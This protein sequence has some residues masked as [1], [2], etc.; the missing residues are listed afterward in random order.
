LADL[1]PQELWNIARQR[2]TQEYIL[3]Q[4]EGTVKQQR[5]QQWH[6]DISDVDLVYQGNAPVRNLDETIKN[7]GWKVTNLV[8]ANADD[9]SRLTEESNDSV[10]CH[11]LT[12]KDADEK[13]ARIRAAIARSWWMAGDG[14]FIKPEL[15]LDYAM[16]GAMFLA[17]VVRPGNPY[18]EPRR[19]D[20]RYAYPSLINNDPRYAY[21]SL[22]N[23]RLV[24]LMVV[25]TV[26]AREARALWGDAFDQGWDGNGGYA[27]IYAQIKNR[28][29]SD[30]VDIVDY[31]GPDALCTA[32]I[33]K[34]GGKGT[35][36]FFVQF[37][38]NPLNGIDCMRGRLPVAFRKRPTGN[39]E[40]RGFLSQSI[41]KQMTANRIRSLQLDFAQ[42]V[43]NSPWFERGT[44]LEDQTID[45]ETVIHGRDQDALLQRIG[46]PPTSPLPDSLVSELEVA[47]R[48]EGSFP[49]SRQGDIPQSIASAAFVDATQGERS[50][51]IRHIN[52]RLSAVRQEWNEV[53]FAMAPAGEAKLLVPVEGRKS[54][55]PTKDIWLDGQPEIEN[56]VTNS[57]GSGL[58]KLNQY[59]LLNQLVGNQLIPR[60]LAMEQIGEVSDVKA[61]QELQDKE[62]VKTAFMQKLL[63][64]PNSD[65]PFLGKLLMAMGSGVDIVTALGT[66]QEELARMA[67]ATQAQNAPPPQ[68]GLAP[69]G[70]EGAPANPQEQLS[71]VKG[72]VPGQ[73]PELQGSGSFQP[74]PLPQTQ[75]D[76]GRRT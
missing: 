7:E 21:P 61:A 54:Y 22:I 48:N 74:P 24:D 71:L 59:S 28:K 37:S 45:A 34:S 75:I 5:L 20:P 30:Q 9:I 39:D 70:T 41:G 69:T 36:A 76:I 56:E 35:G 2:V 1:T 33:A 38:P 63:S 26:H 11:A 60:E 23:N 12:D 44:D 13:R 43:I 58:G 15:A 42:Q 4:W 51:M 73:A 6:A 49:P 50:T 57:I 32:I 46:P 10:Q 64:D 18:P 3:N 67:A 40:L 25:Q 52:K 14:D 55:N 31:Y 66:V 19:I 65:V 47:Q 72:G 17:C 68:P 16:A 27:G 8:Q 29:N 62:L 53:A